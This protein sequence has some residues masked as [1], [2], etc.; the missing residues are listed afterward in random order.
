MGIVVNVFGIVLAAF[1]VWW[2]WMAKSGSV[3]RAEG[4]TIEI[5]VDGGVY[6]PSLLRVPA[7]KPVTLRFLRKDPSP[8]AEK[9]IFGGLDISADLPV[10]EP[11]DLEIAPTKPGEYDFTCQMAMYRGKLIV[12][13]DTK[14]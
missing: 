5:T 10:G 8:C 4:N 6:T 12:E 7:G 11:Y 3:A 1:I 13:R 14:S 2:F 9:V